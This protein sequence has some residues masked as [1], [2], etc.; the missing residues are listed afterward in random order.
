MT[1]ERTRALGMPLIVL[2]RA[3]STN[4]ELVAR[5]TATGLP[6]F[7]TVVTLDQTAGRGRLGRE[8]VSPA[9]KAL[10]VSVLLKP[11]VD[12]EHWGWIPLLAGVAMTRA[13]ARM[14]PDASVSLKW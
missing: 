13:V 8:W 7:T 2:D 3:E 4:D 6:E 1:F 14:I 11:G 12:S 5:A 9:G 10:A